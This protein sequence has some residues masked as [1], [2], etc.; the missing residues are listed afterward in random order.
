MIFKGLSLKQVKY[1]F[2]KGE[3]PT[4]KVQSYKLYNNI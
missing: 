1:F 4:L 3:R 2:F